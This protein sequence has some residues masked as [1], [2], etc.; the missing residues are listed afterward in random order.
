MNQIT[1]DSSLG[2]R[3]RVQPGP[4]EVRDAAGQV[5]GYFTPVADATLYREAEIPVSEEELRRR[6]A[7]G[8]GRPLQEILDDLHR[9]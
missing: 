7:E 6:A 4:V 3:F 2:A 9:R 8:G 5:L 1:V